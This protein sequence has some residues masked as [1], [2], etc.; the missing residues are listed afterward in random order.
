MITKEQLATP[1]E[2]FWFRGMRVFVT[3]FGYNSDDDKDHPWECGY[4]KFKT[5]ILSHLGPYKERL[6]VFLNEAIH[7]SQVSITDAT[8]PASSPKTAIKHDADKPRLDLIPPEALMAVGEVFAYGAE[9]YGDWNWRKGMAH[10]RLVS[11]LMRHL[12][13][14]QMG[15]DKDPESGYTHLAH[16]TCNA[17]MLLGSYLSEDGVDDRWKGG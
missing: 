15:E 9:K 2:I 10:S 5:L 3:E 7:Y 13:A 8:F 11:A 6:D 12:M 17:L 4:V 14:H 16:M 1:G